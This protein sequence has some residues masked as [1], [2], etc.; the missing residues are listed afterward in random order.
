MNPDFQARNLRLLFGLVALATG[1]VA[2]TSPQ[3]LLAAPPDITVEA[4]DVRTGPDH[5]HPSDPVIWNGQLFFSAD[6]GPCSSARGRELHT[7]GIGTGPILVKDLNI[8]SGNCDGVGQ[9][10]ETYAAGLADALI[11]RARR[12]GYN[13]PGFQPYRTQGTDGTTELVADIRSGSSFGSDPQGMT[14]VFGGSHV[15]FAATHGL[16]G[17]EPWITDG[18]SGG[19]RPA[20]NIAPDDYDSNPYYFTPL[21]A[22]QFVFVADDDDVGDFE[23][24]VSDGTTSTLIKDIH[25][26][27]YRSSDI[28]LLTSFVGKDKAVFYA[29]DDTAGREPWVTDGTLAGTFRLADINPGTGSSNTDDTGDNA[30]FVQVGNK[31]FFSADDGT[32]GRELWVTDGT[33][34]GT[35][36][37]TEIVAGSGGG[38]FAQAAAFQGKLWFAAPGIGLWHSDGTAGGTAPLVEGIF[39]GA[40]RELTAVGNVLYFTSGGDL[41]ASD[42]TVP[43]TLKVPSFNPTYSP[44]A[45]TAVNSNVLAFWAET[46]EV[47]REMF[48]AYPTSLGPD[49][50]GPIVLP[51]TPPSAPLGT[52]EDW[53]FTATAHD[54]DTGNSKIFN[55]EFQL[56]GG[57]WYDL[58]PFDA[59]DSPVETGIDSVRFATI[60][61]HELCARGIDEHLN[62]GDPTCVDVPVASDDTTPPP[63]PQVSVNPNPVM[64]DTV[65]TLSITGTDVGTGDRDI[66]LIEYQIDGGSWQS[67][68]TPLDGAYDEPTETARELLTF[69]I[70][71]VKDLCA[72]ATDD[73]FNTSSAGCTQL[74][75]DA[76][77]PTLRLRAIEVNQVIQNWRNSIRLVRA[78]PTVVRIFIEKIDSSSPHFVN[79]I[80]H[81]SIGGN[82]LPE[83]PLVT[84]QRAITTEDATAFTLVD[85]NTMESW[86]ADLGSSI[87]FSLPSAWIDQSGPLELEFAL[88]SPTD[89]VV[90]CAEPDGS[91]DCKV[92]VTFQEAPRPLMEFF[93]VP[94]ARNERLEL[95]ITGGNGGA[96]RFE[97]AGRRSIPILFDASEAFIESA[98]EDVLNSRD[99]RVVVECWTG[100]GASLPPIDRTFGITISRGQD[101]ELL[102]VENNVVGSVDIVELEKGGPIIGPED[103]DLREQARRISDM[104][105]TSGVDFRLRHMNAYGKAPTLLKVNNKLTR[106]GFTDKALGSWYPGMK[107]YALLLERGPS[108][109]KGGLAGLRVAST[110]AGDGVPPTA[111]SYKRAT[112]V[113]EAAH[114]FNRAHAVVLPT[115]SQPSTV[116]I[117]LC[118]SKYNHFTAPDHPFVEYTGI[119]HDLEHDIDP[120]WAFWWPTIGPLEE[121]A[122]SEIW[123][124]SP[125][126]YANGS[127]FEKLTIVDPRISAELMSYCSVPGSRQGRWVSTFTYDIL[128]DRIRNAEREAESQAPSGAFGDYLIISGSIDDETG[129]VEFDPAIRVTGLDPGNDPGDLKVALLDGFGA[130]TSSQFVALITDGEYASL[131]D[132]MGPEPASFVAALAIPKGSAP[133]AIAISL[134]STEI[135]RIDG[136]ANTPTVALTSPAGATVASGTIPIAWDAADLDGDSLTTT[137]LYS[138]DSGITWETLAVDFEGTSYDAPTRFLQGSHSAMIKLLVSDGFHTTEATSPPFTL[139]AG[140][141]SASIEVPVNGIAVDFGEILRLRG[142]AWDPEDGMLEGS[143][144]EWSVEYSDPFPGHDVLGFGE[145]LDVEAY[146]LPP[147]CQQI[148]LSATDTDGHHATDT[149]TVDIGGTGC[150]HPIFDDGFESGN[151][152]PW[153][154]SR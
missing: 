108:S 77:D 73:G 56:D 79:G 61:I 143:R 62:V 98:A 136:S 30:G 6:E 25:P 80:L 151:L 92:S 2:S 90:E 118:G 58:E 97:S 86:R 63:A 64:I 29:Y 126:A 138:T 84:N 13:D 111:G 5:G 3:L 54:T 154:S 70:P 87:N 75:V 147:G 99:G 135:A 52:F 42:G 37:V 89:Q 123:G 74:Q 23:L 47:G 65:T 20:G 60:G 93:A 122:D 133:A 44:Q 96:F 21:S 41:W 144:L 18:T 12:L 134:D 107:S 46:A 36:L 105:P 27:P 48:L 137:I 26:V 57:E 50:E 32:T 82:P 153:S 8:Q 139:D 128:W 83:S 15:V 16:W 69:D 142:D 109:T 85:E 150:L 4:I 95:R 113:H 72:R 22:S 9:F 120:L 31:M 71:G 145:S 24:Y 38:Y 33:S 114:T 76:P 101:E 34:T 88:T 124:F 51:I 125:R 119:R 11:F 17:R 28:Q 140:Y 129:E 10:L 149:V 115:P 94:Y 66:I 35:R 112:A 103:N 121:G 117:G 127:D 106:I 130:E 110:Y 59:Y 132:G 49:T 68:L 53:Y 141:P 148:V 1:L 19:T 78:K 39:P 116:R 55:I 131:A 67:I 81:G 7:A 45:L 146:Q 102:I 40:I 43:G 104:F 91:S 100:C 14:T 152:S